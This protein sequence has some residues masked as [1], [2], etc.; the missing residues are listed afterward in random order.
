MKKRYSAKGKKN[1]YVILGLLAVLLGSLA[2]LAFQ[3]GTREGLEIKKTVSS[4]KKS[5]TDESENKTEK[6]PEEE[7]EPEPK[8]AP[9]PKKQGTEAALTG[10]LTSL[11]GKA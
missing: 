9:K 3:K 7:P 2:Y 5:E 11:F 6:E 10:M 4:V 8:P 1:I